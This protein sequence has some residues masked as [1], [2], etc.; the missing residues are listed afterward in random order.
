MDKNQARDREIDVLRQDIRSGRF[1]AATSACAPGLMQLNLA[2][3]PEDAAPDFR[4]FCD[5]NS[6]P[7]P[8]LAVSE[9]GA[10]LKRVTLQPFGC[11]AKLR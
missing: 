6:R 4:A 1:T 10:V 2:I 3:V 8:L 5:S 11:L 7:C 9:P